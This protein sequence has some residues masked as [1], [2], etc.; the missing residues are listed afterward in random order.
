MELKALGDEHYLKSEY[1]DAISYY[2]LALN[3]GYEN[4]YILYLN[5]GLSYIKLGNNN[6]A[7][8]DTTEAIKLKSDNA[9]AWGRLGSILTLLKKSNNAKIAYTKAYNLDKTNKIFKN[10]LEKYDY[11]SDTDTED[12][13]YAINKNIKELKEMAI[14]FNKRGSKTEI[15]NSL[16]KNM[17]TDNFLTERLND[18]DFQ[19]KILNYSKNPFDALKDNE[20]LSMMKNLIK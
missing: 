11:N 10:L 3:V 12:E 9:K 20:I 18:K 1:L 13:D 6:M 4:K 15:I 2:T 14:N 5:R 7:L 16:I 17:M 8:S 19:N